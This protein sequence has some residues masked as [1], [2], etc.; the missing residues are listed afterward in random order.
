MAKKTKTSKTKMREFGTGA[1]RDGDDNKLS[2]V[3]ALCPLVLKR[4]VEYIGKHRVQADGNLRD[5]DN[6]KQGIPED[7]YMD[8]KARHLMDSW[9]HHDGFGDEAICDDLEDVLCAEIFNTMGFLRE[10]LVRKYNAK[11]KLSEIKK[12]SSKIKKR[13]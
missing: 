2:F 9:L 13:R 6:W 11:K 1:T 12:R 10:I 4:Y 7:V 3:K 5:W 8:S